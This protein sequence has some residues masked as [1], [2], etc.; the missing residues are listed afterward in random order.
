MSFDALPT[1]IVQIIALH[2]GAPQTFGLIDRR[3]HTLDG[4]TYRMLVQKYSQDESLV[5][6]IFS[7]SVRQDPLS[8]LGRVK[9]IY[10]WVML[11]V[12]KAEVPINNSLYPHDQLNPA[13]LSALVKAAQKVKKTKPLNRWI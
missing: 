7:D 9:L 10:E 1:A 11:K 12:K 5:S 8:P 4:V 13:R 2:V 3:C 6:H